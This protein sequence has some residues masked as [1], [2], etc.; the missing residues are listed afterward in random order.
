VKRR[1]LYLIAGLFT[2]SLA[3]G[4]VALLQP[5]DDNDN[6]PGQLSP[7]DG[8]IDRSPH[9]QGF[10]SSGDIRLEYLE[11]GRG[12]REEQ[13]PIVFLAGLG[14]TAHIYDEIAPQFADTFRVI[15]LTRRGVG[16]SEKPTHSY[17]LATLVDDIR[18]ALDALGIHRAI[19]V[20]HSFGCQEA[21]A[22]A[23]QYP[24]RVARII[25]LDGAYQ[26]SPEL[27]ELNSQVCE[28]LPQYSEEVGS[29]FPALL[30]WHR[31]NRAGWN[32]AC[33]ADF[34]ST[35]VTR[36]EGISARSSTP[37]VIFKLIDSV[38]ESPADF[39]KVTSPA[40]AIF[41]DHQLDELLARLEAP[42]RR[43]AVP[44]V[45]RF[46]QAQHEQVERFKQN[47]K[48]AQVVE[49]VDADHMC[50]TQ[51]PQQVVEAMRQF[52]IPAN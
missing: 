5:H 43:K 28:F 36:P 46:A 13:P 24:D 10:I 49:L 3:V 20:G 44:L 32:E 25:Y 4:A 50:F 19:L 37:D 8:W 29:S 1:I 9:K 33:E 2:L 41:A 23:I 12:P 14:L 42:A 15:A 11:W 6:D 38:A 21:A 51:R 39:S 35:R 45:Q 34:R 18:Q 26:I 30:D 48:N 17:S 31:N 47:V 22:F 7:H 52:L 27:N 16:A 40:L